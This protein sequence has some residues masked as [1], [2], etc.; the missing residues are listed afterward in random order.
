MNIF[1]LGATGRVGQRI[2]QKALDDKQQ[3][4]AL[5]RTPEKL[6]VTSNLLT[7]YQGNALDQEA[8]TDAMANNDVVISALGTDKNQTL[9]R[10]M[11]LIRRAMKEHDLSRIITIGTA[12]ILD[13]R[14]QTGRYRFQT[15]ESKRRS[16]TA[17]EDHLAAY[18]HLANSN[19]L[20]TVIC[21][22]YLP[23]GDEKR[24]YRVEK[25]TLPEN[26]KQI[27]VGDTAA[28]A[29]SQLQQKK[30]YQ[31]RVGMAY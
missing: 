5:L 1:M 6:T 13:S 24:Q 29:Y 3:V 27:T 19:L 8:L 16:T 22:T 20:W 17:A 21:P 12:G 11:P 14:T 25:N 31:T 23:D 7:V 26:G 4:T 10:S 18:N 9:S 28:F 2:V 15:D 30:F